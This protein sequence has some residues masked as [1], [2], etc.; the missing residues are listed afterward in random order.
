MAQQEDNG[1]ILNERKRGKISYFCSL[2][3]CNINEFNDLCVLIK[4]LLLY[5]QKQS[6]SS[7]FFRSTKFVMNIFSS[8]TRIHSVLKQTKPFKLKILGTNRASP[9][10]MS[11]DPMIHY[12]SNSK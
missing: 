11:R 4:V 9:L 3:N 1:P 7:L 12:K 8:K 6:L 10:L 2:K 5:I